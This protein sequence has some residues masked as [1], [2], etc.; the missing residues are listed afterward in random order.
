MYTLIALLC[1]YPLSLHMCVRTPL[2]ATLC[3]PTQYLNVQLCIPLITQLCVY[4][5]LLSPLSV[6]PPS[7]MWYLSEEL[8]IRS[9]ADKES[10]DIK[11]RMAAKLL[12]T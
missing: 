1:I 7:Y 11:S 9:F 3:A 6:Y 2:M 12:A 8:C 10:E 5:S 4:P